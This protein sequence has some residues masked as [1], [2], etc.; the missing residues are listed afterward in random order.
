MLFLILV[1]MVYV[2]LKMFLIYCAAMFLDLWKQNLEKKCTMFA[3]LDSQ[4]DFFSFS[5]WWK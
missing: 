2:F 5:I 3:C 4:E 1:Y